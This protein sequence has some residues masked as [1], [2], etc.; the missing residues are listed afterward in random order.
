[1]AIFHHFCLKICRCKSYTMVRSFANF[2][3]LTGFLPDEIVR[4]K[5][6]CYSRKVVVETHFLYM[7][8]DCDNYAQITI[9]FRGERYHFYR[10]QLSLWLKLYEDESFDMAS[11]D[12]TKLTSHLCTKKRCI[13]PEH[14]TL[15]S[16]DKNIE[17]V[18]CF[19]DRHCYGHG[20]TFPT[21]IV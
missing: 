2:K 12:E 13:N 8:R 9:D 10:H 21:C 20:V 1:M 17:R 18:R 14:L 4:L 7:G 3:T 11:W 16:M 15:E 6:H 19:E 5:E